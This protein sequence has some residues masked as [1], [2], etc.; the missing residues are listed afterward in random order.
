MERQSQ[1]IPTCCNAC[2][3]QTGVFAHVVDG[4][5]IKL[6]PNQYNPIGVA[7]TYEEFIEEK[8][9]G[10]R[11]CPKGLCAIKQLNDPERLTKPMK[12]VGKDQWQ[13]IS[14][15][16]AFD[17][18]VERLGYIKENYGPE[19]LLWFSEDHSFTHIQMDFC[20]AYGTPNY[21]MH[22]N[23]CDVARKAGFK[24]TMGDE[25]PIAD[26]AHS[27]YILIF[28]WNPLATSK[29]AYLPAAFM[30][31][32]EKGAKLVVVDPVFTATAAKATEW[33]PIRPGTDGTM[34]L[35]IGNVIVSEELYDKEF[36]EQWTNGFE[37]YQEYIADKT[38]EWAEEITGVSAET[39]IRIAR[40]VAAAKPAVIDTWSGVSHYS[41]GT[42]ATRAVAM[43]SGLLGQIDQPGTMLI[44][45]R[46]GPKHRADLPEWPKITAPRVDGLGTKY[47]FAHKAGVHVEAREAMLTGEPYQPKAAVFVFQNF[48]KSLPNIKKSI[49]ALK[50]LGFV[51]VV[52][53]YLSETALEADLVIPGSHFLERYDLT[54]NWV[55]FPSMS[56]RQPVVEPRA[57]ILPEYE[58]VMELARRL[59]VPGFDMPYESL[60]DAEL[61][62][63]IGIGLEELKALPGA[64][65]NQGPTKYQKYQEKGF[66]TPSGKFEFY[67]E[68]MLKVG[69]QPLPDVSTIQKVSDHEFPLAIINW[70]CMEHTHSR[71]QNNPWLMEMEGDNPLIMHSETAD[72]LGLVDGDW[73]V[74][75]SRYGKQESKLKVSPEIHPAA[76]GMTHGFGHWGLGK[77]AKGKGTAVNHFYKG[78]AER[79]SGQAILKEGFVKVYKREDQSCQR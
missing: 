65:W 51:M 2:G 38:P 55:A 43:L 48:V 41:T 62:S 77:H 15:N 67:S 9:R 30:K 20:K 68:A 37:Q 16:E 56:L 6:E 19:K 36:V 10:A 57:G 11:M 45:E 66:N 78:E 4:Q 21:L 25:R 63:S 8:A 60:L 27:K 79:L 50:N 13:E 59:G 18:A 71:S 53:Q 29:W 52:D 47:P 76:V 22:A 34:A 75:E 14:W 46:K 33:V 5:V 69:L 12:R 24:L 73:V 74:I 72:S 58:F 49:E 28:G 26:I 23:L 61:R 39:I 7:N 17:I 64:V 32:L 3:G 40:E 70:K 1:V 42:E 44:P 35:A 31:A 54:A